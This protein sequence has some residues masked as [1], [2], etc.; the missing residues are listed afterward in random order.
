MQPASGADID[1][2][3][4]LRQIQLQCHVD[5]QLGFRPGNQ[6]SRIDPER[7]AVKLTFT[8][9]VGD[10]NTFG[11]PVEQ[12][13]EVRCCGLILNRVVQMSKTTTR[14]RSRTLRLTGVRT[15]V[16]F[17]S[18]PNLHRAASGR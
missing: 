16:D 17:R 8:E 10:R 13:A 12:V 2:R 18:W 7:S 3:G 4:S 14:D 1:N 6:N 11:T 5:Q 15:P 9:Q